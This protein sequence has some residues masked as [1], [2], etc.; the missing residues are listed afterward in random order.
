[1]LPSLSAVSGTQICIS[2]ENGATAEEMLGGSLSGPSEPLLESDELARASSSVRALAKSADR[3]ARR[4]FPRS[5]PQTQGLSV[6][7]RPPRAW[8]KASQHRHLQATGGS[9]LAAA[10]GRLGRPSRGCG[11]RVR[12]QFSVRERQRT[13]QAS[14]PVCRC[15]V[16]PHLRPFSRPSAACVGSH[17]P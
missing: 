15:A 12:R 9:A 10:S 5:S 7:S 11:G 6:H 8:C 2:A 16:P 1:M 3:M 17:R 14:P 4:Y 13:R